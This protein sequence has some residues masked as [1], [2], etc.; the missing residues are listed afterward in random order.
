MC[1]SSQKNP[2]QYTATSSPWNNKFLVILWL[3]ELFSGLFVAIFGTICLFDFENRDYQYDDGILWG[4][5]QVF[6]SSTKQSNPPILPFLKI[7][8]YFVNRLLYMVC[9]M[10]LMNI[11]FLLIQVLQYRKH[12]L[13]PGFMVAMQ[14]WNVFLWLA[15]VAI[16]LWML[17][18]WAQKWAVFEVVEL[19][20][21]FAAYVLIHYLLHGVILRLLTGD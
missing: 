3:V 4:F 10:V 14:C 20:Y 21:C 18:D 9:S 16:T 15:I 8:T 1:C 11:G 19:L 5:Y 2:Y 12:K 13:H 6:V 7:L 17:I